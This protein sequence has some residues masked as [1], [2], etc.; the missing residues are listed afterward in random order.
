M[1]PELNPSER[2]NSSSKAMAEAM[3]WV[4]RIT[5]IGLEMALPALIGRWMDE[6]YQ[7]SFWFPIGV[8][9]GPILGFWHLLVITG[10]IGKEQDNGHWPDDG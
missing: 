3:V 6:R 10:V 4:S 1:E 9:A 2:D 7:T 5:A 8:V